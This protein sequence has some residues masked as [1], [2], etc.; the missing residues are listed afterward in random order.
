MP[1]INLCQNLSVRFVKLSFSVCWEEKP[2]VIEFEGEFIPKM[3]FSVAMDRF[4]FTFTV[5]D[6]LGLYCWNW[7]FLAK[8]DLCQFFMWGLKKISH[9][10]M[11]W[12]PKEYLI[13]NFRWMFHITIQITRIPNAVIWVLFV[14]LW[15]EHL[16]QTENIICLNILAAVKCKPCVITK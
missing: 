3:K 9:I 7:L 1:F 11:H 12:N 5:W 6:K 14:G 8:L 4:Y 10:I 13:L 2:H 15:L 16:K